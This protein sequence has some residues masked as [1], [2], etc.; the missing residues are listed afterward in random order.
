MIRED[1][2]R[3]GGGQEGT[4]GGFLS[5]FLIIVREGFE[6][7]LVI[8]AIVAYLIK[9]G[10]RDKVRVIYRSAIIAI[11]ASVA[12]AFTVRY[13]FNISGA[14]QEFLEGA[15]MLLAVV[16]LFWVSFWLLSKV[17]AQRWQ[18][19]IQS[20]VARSLT[21]GSTLALGSAA[22]LAVYREGAKTVLFYQALLGG[23]AGRDATGIWLGLAV[24]LAV[25]AV[26]FIAIRWGS[27]RVPIKPF[28][29]VTGAFLYYMAFMFAG[30]GIR[31]LQEAGSIGTSLVPG[32]PAI[33]A[34]GVYPTGEGLALQGLL[35]LLAAG[36]LVYQFLVKPRLAAAGSGGG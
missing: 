7:L 5:S 26:I 13:L 27:L 31:E 17:E 28:F 2:G 9:S 25:L 34:L 21:A 22:F 14:S 33:T 11:L 8:G 4:G 18:N 6:A 12:T 23:P 15:T 20:R 3:L 36:A 29:I 35:L 24:G 16:V 1:A 19:Y 30:E 10:N 32:I